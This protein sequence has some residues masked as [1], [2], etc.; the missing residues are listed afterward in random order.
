MPKLRS[1]P[2]QVTEASLRSLT[3]LSTIFHHVE[4]AAGEMGSWIVKN[5]CS[6]LEQQIKA[7]PFNEHL[8]LV[9][10]K[11]IEKWCV[12]GQWIFEPVSSSGKRPVVSRVLELIVIGLTGRMGHV[13]E[14]AWKRDQQGK[15]VP[16]P[17]STVHYFIPTTSI[18]SIA[19]RILVSLMLRAAN[20]PREL[21]PSVVSSLDR[22]DSILRSMK[23]KSNHNIGIYAFD[24]SIFTF[25]RHP[26]DP[27]T[28]DFNL[29]II[30]RDF[31]G[32]YVWNV[33]L[34]YLEKELEEK[35][36][37]YVHQ[38]NQDNP[39]AV[40]PTDKIN[41]NILYSLSY[42]L[43]D[44]EKQFHKLLEDSLNTRIKNEQ[45]NKK[46]NEINKVQQP[47]I[48]CLDN[49]VDNASF[50]IILANLGFINPL[51]RNRIVCIKHINSSVD[52]NFEEVF[53]EIDSTQERLNIEVGVLYVGKGLSI[54]DMLESN[55]S[56]EY[57]EFIENLGWRIEL[58]THQ[59][60][61]GG[62][63]S[64][65]TGPYARYFADYNHEVMFHVATL[66]PNMKGNNH[67]INL[68]FNDSI[69][70]I[71][72]EDLVESDLSKLNISANTVIQI[73]PLPSLLF[74]VTIRSNDQIIGPLLNNCVV[75]K[76]ALPT[77]VLQTCI[78]CVT[79]TN[80]SFPLERRSLILTRVIEKYGHE[81][82]FGE[83]YSNLFKLG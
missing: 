17:D 39:F 66:M 3:E 43:G 76:H 49:E 2:N 30:I 28:G 52:I 60:Y 7:K 1:W 4:E 54:V 59:G 80:S 23:V 44:Q 61:F 16:L 6:F 67:K 9:I 78:A 58:K 36:S 19:R 34:N 15:R 79:Y 21:G 22:E 27:I 68:V 8:I 35:E 26:R 65:I 53:N 74:R 18:L 24:K 83:L 82:S 25:I 13:T 48:T 47:P 77:F 69:L 42:F 63:N 32:R 81:V 37:T 56:K 73:T 64:D 51:N 5:L 11:C 12:T 20:F 10:Y 38:V 46:K 33:R 55:G 72:N 41:D 45:N 57:N 14:S 62:L 50:R 71:W 70:V 29:T 31:S 75:T 40:V